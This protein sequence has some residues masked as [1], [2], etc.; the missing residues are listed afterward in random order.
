MTRNCIKECCR[1]KVK[2]RKG[3]RE[4]KP[5]SLVLNSSALL[6][7]VVTYKSYYRR[8][9]LNS[10]TV[11][12]NHLISKPQY[13]S[14]RSDKG[15]RNDRSVWRRCKSYAAVNSRTRHLRLKKNKRWWGA[16]PRPID[17]NASAL[18]L[19]HSDLL[20]FYLLSAII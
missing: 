14:P 20:Y 9:H 1:G 4:A 12:P 10:N 15:K 11:T 17:W 2:K 7:P 8:V 13:A 19:H 3:W 16:N 5:L 6:P 18:P